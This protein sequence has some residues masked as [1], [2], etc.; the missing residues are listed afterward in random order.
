VLYVTDQELERAARD[1]SYPRVEIRQQLF[2]AAEGHLATTPQ[3]LFEIPRARNLFVWSSVFSELG[4]ACALTEDERYLAHLLVLTDA[5]ADRWRDGDFD[6]H[7]HVPYL[8][9]TLAAF[10]D[11]H[12][13]RLDDAARALLLRMLTDMTEHVWEDI[14]H[15]NWGRINRTAWNHNA[16]GYTSLA[17]AG[18]ALREHPLSRKWLNIGLTRTQRFI[19]VGVTPA[20]MTWE[21]LNYCG[22]VFKH[23]S[24][25]LAAV[26]NLGWTDRY[27]PAGSELEQRLAR[28]P[29]WYAHS[30]F[31]RGSYLQNY[32]D[33]H[34]DPHSALW[35][36][37]RGFGHL[38]P[39]LCAAVWERLVGRSGMGTYGRHRVRSSVA[40][41]LL[42]FPPV[43]V[44]TGALDR[45]EE[46]FSCADSG[47][48]SVHDRRGAESSVFTFNSGPFLGH[49]HDQADNNSFTFIARGNP[50]VLDSG[51]ANRATEDSPSSSVG[52]NTVLIDGRGEHVAGEWQ[53]VSGSI[54]SLS[55]TDDAVAVVGDAS[56]SYGLDEYNPVLWARRSA[57]F[58][59]R[60][61]PYL[62]TFDDIAKDGGTHHYEH[63]LH[64]P[65]GAH[66]AVHDGHTQVIVCA[67]DGHAAG[68]VH[69]LNPTE[70]TS[71]VSEF[72]SS[73]APY[74]R[75][76][77]WRFGADAT[78]PYFVVAFTAATG[79]HPV[80]LHA[81]R[82]RRREVRVTVTW[83]DGED[84]IRFP[85]AAKARFGR[86]RPARAPTF[87]RGRRRRS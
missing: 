36:F 83:P 47:F 75:H 63:L 38:Q 35:G 77:L 12:R 20:G 73:S 60:P 80:A 53:G 23:L 87:T 44:D 85:V 67:G 68:I 62:V 79:P 30:V 51:S 81:S 21:G 6:G 4:L 64:L 34:W 26:R 42:C 5:L 84:V 70:I 32:N 50:I 3:Q 52:H 33:S 54:V 31:P 76:D 56:E 18:L 55:R 9:C 11:L 8:M 69:V 13:D 41:A 49:V 2:A 25:L 86:E 37:L 66:T 29:T 19:E 22:L 15:K 59:L 16:V 78:N 58:V 17:I 82:P 7:I 1:E 27:V 39:E 61:V 14:Q 72:R 24:M 45:I 28:I 43:S 71:E 10:E 48:V 57:M 40:E 74:V 46:V 65:S